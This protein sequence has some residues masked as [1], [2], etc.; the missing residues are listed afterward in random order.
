VTLSGLTA[1]AL[2]PSVVSLNTNI[3]LLRR[4]QDRENKSENDLV[5]AKMC[6][7]FVDKFQPPSPPSFPSPSL[8][9]FPLS[10]PF[11]YTRS[12]SSESSLSLSLSLPLYKVHV[13]RHLTS[14]TLPPCLPPR[15]CANGTDLF[16]CLS[17]NAVHGAKVRDHLGSFAR[18]SSMT[19]ASLDLGAASAGEVSRG[20]AIRSVTIGTA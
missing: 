13:P 19:S 10:S 12:P 17:C 1:G 2:S 11:L 14:H 5:G 7:L 20:G 8:P 16:I 9:P 15:L 6:L 3:L 18:L 4:G